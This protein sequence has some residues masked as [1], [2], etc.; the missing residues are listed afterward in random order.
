MKII[1]VGG[2]GTI[3]NKVTADLEKDHEVIKVGRTSG[4]IQADITQPESIEVMFKTIG[5]F[6][7][8]VSI[9]GTGHFGPLKTMT[10]ADFQ[11]GLQSK[12]LGQVNLVLI[13]QHYINPKGSFTLTSGILSEDPV[14]GSANLAAVN[15]ALN[16]FAMAAALEL[17]NDV[18]INVVSPG[19]VEDSPEL[20]GAFPGHMPV[21]MPVVV[22]AY[23]KSVLGVVNGQVIKA[24]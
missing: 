8:L 3:G 4:D 5:S 19:V 14:F 17:E 24:F 20:F 2:A 6:D 22:N 23:R 9:S 1:I 21:S 11:V 15:A 10:A 12:L 13:G 7:A 18:R 16:S